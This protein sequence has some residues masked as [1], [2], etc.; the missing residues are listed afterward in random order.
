MDTSTTLSSLLISIWWVLGLSGATL[1]EMAQVPTGLEK[2]T[3]AGGCFWCMEPPFDKLKG[4]ISTTS[5]YT[6]GYKQN[7]TYE[8]VSAGGTGHAEAV[9]VIY[10]PHSISY[11]QLLEVFWHNIDPLTSNRQF[12]DK[13]NQYRSAIFYHSEEQKRLAEQSKKALEESR[14]FK[15]P[16]VTELVPASEFY[17]A[18]EYHQ[19]Y[20]L[21]NPI[22]YKF[23]RYTCGRDQRLEELWGKPG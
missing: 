16:I 20:Y 2:A 17:P 7:P 22:R 6:G 18:E 19:D 12:C 3:F 9:Q 15:R 11:A 5:G 23:Y 1:A 14:G 13:G 21:K 4:V 10:D 8:E